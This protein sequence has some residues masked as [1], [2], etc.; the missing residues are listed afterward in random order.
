MTFARG[1]LS[2]RHRATEETPSER[3]IL[4]VGLGFS[5]SSPYLIK[6]GRGEVLALFISILPNG[7]M[8]TS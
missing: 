8:V 4:F 1:L 6:G 5:A 2:L 3:R 7:K